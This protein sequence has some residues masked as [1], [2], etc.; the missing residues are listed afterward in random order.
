[1]SKNYIRYACVGVDKCKYIFVHCA[2]FVYLN[3]MIA[4]V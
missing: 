3:I 1:M 4:L 2:Y